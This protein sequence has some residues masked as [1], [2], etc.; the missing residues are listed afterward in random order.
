MT[1]P[2]LDDDGKI[3]AAISHFRV[4]TSQLVEAAPRYLR[5]RYCFGAGYFGTRWHEGQN[6][7]GA[8]LYPARTTARRGRRECQG[9][10]QPCGLSESP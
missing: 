3:A 6:G 4:L 9:S 1:G 7:A 5:L 8:L 10:P 2:S